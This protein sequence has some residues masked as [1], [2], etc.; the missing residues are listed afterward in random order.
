M[1]A[2]AVN[3]PGFSIIS[4]FSNLNN[5]GAKESSSI[6]FL[7]FKKN[8]AMLA[9]KIVHIYYVCVCLYMCTE[10]ITRHMRGC[11]C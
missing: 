8:S 5:G 2:Q 4:S 1:I 3:I 6:S 7:V 10:A 9:S 11:S